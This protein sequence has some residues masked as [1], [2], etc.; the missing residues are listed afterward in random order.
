MDWIETKKKLSK[1]LYGIGAIK[2]GEFKLVS[3]KTSPY[4]IDLRIVPSFPDAYDFI[5]DA[6]ID[7]LKEEL[8]PD[9]SEVLV[10]VP[11]AGIPLASLIA[12]KMKLPMA[13]VRKQAKEHGTGRRVEGVIKPGQRV[14]VID[15]LITSGGSNME[16]IKALREEGFNAGDVV[17]L[18]DR[19][20]GGI[21]RLKEEGII[22]R[23]IMT[24]L[25][26]VDYLEED[27]VIPEEQAKTI[28]AYVESEQA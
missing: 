10:G 24:V 3:G 16:V 11:T 8:E 19:M 9:G 12:Y 28:R 25:E 20:Q 26:I 14:I 17:L 15:D 13:Y 27:G 1:M 7:K 5:T 2:F 4:Y 18:V 23:P 22:V 21:K 6:Y